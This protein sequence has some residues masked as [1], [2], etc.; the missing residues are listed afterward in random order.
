MRCNYNGGEGMTIK[1]LVCPLNRKN[2]KSGPITNSFYSQY[3]LTNEEIRLFEKMAPLPKPEHNH[4][5]GK[6]QNG[7]AK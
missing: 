7:C 4:E 2:T 1:T 3:K 5:L 6:N